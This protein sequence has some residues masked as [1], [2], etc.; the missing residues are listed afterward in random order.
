MRGGART[1][2]KRTVFFN[3]P[4]GLHILN[5]ECECHKLFNL[6]VVSHSFTAAR[7][8]KAKALGRDILRR[9]TA[10]IRLVCTAAATIIL[11]CKI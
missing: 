5:T 8:L 11:Q 1:L 6:K 4:G 9:T 7:A 10:T 3:F 2:L